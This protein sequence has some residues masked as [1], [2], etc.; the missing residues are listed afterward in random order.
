MILGGCTCGAVMYEITGPV[1]DVYVCHCS[2]C[3]RSTGA[4]GIAVVIVVNESFRW[5][6]GV[7]LVATWRKPDADWQTWF[8]RQCG[9]RVPG[10]DSATHMFVPA[11]S[12]TSGAGALRVAHHIW[13]DS[14]A[15]WDV[16]GDDGV[17][18]AGGIRS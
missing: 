2:I 16:I 11:G 6:A 1:S 4:N 8:C 9:A 14:R 5:R 15:V 3:R 18:H 12:I 7:D 17:Q 10:Q 13:V